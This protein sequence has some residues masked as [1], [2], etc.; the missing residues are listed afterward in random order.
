M[1]SVPNKIM[2][3]SKHEASSTVVGTR[4]LSVNQNLFFHLGAVLLTH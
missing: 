2:V 4:S 3:P 1:S